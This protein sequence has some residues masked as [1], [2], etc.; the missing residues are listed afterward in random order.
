MHFAPFRY[1]CVQKSTLSKSARKTSTN[2]ISSAFFHISLVLKYSRVLNYLL[3][4]KPLNST[5]NVWIIY[6][7]LKKLTKNNF[8][9]NKLDED[10][11]LGVIRL[12]D[13][14]KNRH[15]MDCIA[16]LLLRRQL[17]PLSASALEGSSGLFALIFPTSIIH[18][19]LIQSM[20]DT[21]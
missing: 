14:S 12:L 2:N 20:A 9:C 3:D 8:P 4:F 16:L 11:T 18:A 13:M 19:L 10:G 1:L 21:G 6:Y 17:S 15:K 5:L 7:L